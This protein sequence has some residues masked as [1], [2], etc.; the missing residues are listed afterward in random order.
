MQHLSGMHDEVEGKANQHQHNGAQECWDEAANVEARNEG[1]GQQQDD[2]IDDQEEKAQ[3][4]NAE[5]EGQQL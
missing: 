1:A 5:R 3:G 4:Q 2:G